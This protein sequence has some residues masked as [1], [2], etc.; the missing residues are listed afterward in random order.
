M[1]KF[2]NTFTGKMEEFRPLEDNQVRMY[3]CGPTVYDYAHIGNFRT[4]V[5]EDILHRWLKFKGYRVTHVMNITDIDDKTIRNSKATEVSQLRDYTDRFTEAFFE[6]CQALSIE[7]PDQVVN[8]TNHI[9]DM[10]RLI[11]QLLAKGHA[12]E[13]D[14]SY[15]FKI[16]SF[17]RYGQLAKLNF[18]GM[19]VGASVD[20]DE[21]EKED[22]RDFA[23]WKARKEGEPYWDTPLGKGRPGWHIECSA[24]S[25]RYLGTPFDIHCGAV[26]NIFPHHEN[27]IAQSE[28][29]TG[30]PFV[31]VW[32]HG[33]HL[34]VNGEKMSKSK[35]NFFTLRD[36]LAKGLPPRALRYT[37]ASVPYRKQLNF[38]FESIQQSQSAIERLEDFHL[39]V[40]R[41]R[42]S[43]GLHEPMEE[44]VQAAREK[45]VAGLDED[46]NTAQALAA[47]FE[48]VH[49]GNMALAQGN[50]RAGNRPSILSLFD[51]FQKIFAVLKE[52][53]SQ[54]LDAEVESLMSERQQARRDRNFKRADEIRDELLARGIVLEDTK[55]GVRWKRKH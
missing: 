9:S 51:D 36:L 6:D 23:L 30:K 33:E 15:Y 52:P 48:L 22:L 35:G 18:D 3:T 16:S 38:T 10:V 21:Y 32:L 45:F 34:I 25:M 46:L 26:D 50:L 20:V 29:A 31:K 5:Y 17:P 27:E 24:M 54:I 43:N 19:K 7:R 1:L 4:Y 2:T 28:C 41:D 44:A 11:Q 42:L 13:K 8:A 53:S 37:L 40:E 39:R 12:Y 49:R 47:V 14:G 55:D